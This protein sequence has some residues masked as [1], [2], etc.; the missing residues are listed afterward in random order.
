M[1]NFVIRQGYM[2]QVYSWE[3]DLDVTRT[4]TLDGLDEKQADMY[5]DIAMLL[6]NGLG[7]NC[8]SPSHIPAV[9]EVMVRHAETVAGIFG[10]ETVVDDIQGNDESLTEL[11][12]ELVY[13][14]VGSSENY[15][16]YRVVESINV[17]EI[18]F[19]V[20]FKNVTEQFS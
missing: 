1:N 13:E 17:Y 12:S 11:F 8:M 16:I 19:T 5:Y 6:K 18:P 9:R 10:D 7:N 2:I 4:I 15:D 14:L 3:N 20:E